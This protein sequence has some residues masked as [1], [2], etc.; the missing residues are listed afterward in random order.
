MLSDSN[1]GKLFKRGLTT[2]LLTLSFL[3]KVPLSRCQA[4]ILPQLRRLVIGGANEFSDRPLV[5]LFNSL[6]LDKC[7]LLCGVL[8]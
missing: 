1:A 8:L 5:K 3:Q 4:C 2:L 7:V 6:L